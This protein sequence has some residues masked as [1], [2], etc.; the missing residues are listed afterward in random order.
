MFHEVV[1]SFKHPDVW[2]VLHRQGFL[3]KFCWGKIHPE[4]V[5]S[6]NSDGFVSYYSGVHIVSA[7]KS[8]HTSQIL[9]FSEMKPTPKLFIVTFF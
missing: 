4:K 8:I 6:L 5:G 9:R 7:S 2:H 1:F 3:S